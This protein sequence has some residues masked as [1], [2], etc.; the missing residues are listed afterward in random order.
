MRRGGS[1]PAKHLHQRGEV[2]MSREPESN[3]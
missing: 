3:D 1:I 2:E